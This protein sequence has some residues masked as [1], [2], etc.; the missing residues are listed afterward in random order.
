[1]NFICWL[2]IWSKS[3]PKKDNENYYLNSLNNSTKLITSDERNECGEETEIK[4]RKN[5]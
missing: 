1:M 2:G 4:K 5:K 3:I